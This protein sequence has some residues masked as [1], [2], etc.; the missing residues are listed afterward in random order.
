MAVVSEPLEDGEGDWTEVPE[1]SFCTF[2]REAV[3]VEE[4]MPCRLAL[5]A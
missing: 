4:F 2:E 1:Y 3:R 5:A